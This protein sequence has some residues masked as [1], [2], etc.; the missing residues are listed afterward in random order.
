MAKRKQ[1]GHAPEPWA[2]DGWEESL[3]WIRSTSPS[4]GHGD[5]ICNPPEECLKPS[6]QRWPA[7]ARRIVECVN[8]CQGI[9]PK[10]VPGLVDLAQW[11][12]QRLTLGGKVDSNNLLK[13]ITWAKGILE[14]GGVGSDVGLRAPHPRGGKRRS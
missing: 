6:F 10:V 7:N 9:D 5:V 12:S 11:L 1:F 3:T 4:A 8:A 2:I 14:R 13:A